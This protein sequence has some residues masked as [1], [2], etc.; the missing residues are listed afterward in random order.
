MTIYE[1]TI[2]INVFPVIKSCMKMLKFE[3]DNIS[4]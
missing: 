1:I 3:N 2:K 4:V